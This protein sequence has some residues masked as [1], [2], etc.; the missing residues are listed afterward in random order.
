MKQD[1]ALRYSVIEWQDK[2]ILL[3]NIFV[4]KS[5]IVP[6]AEALILKHSIGQLKTRSWFD[7]LTTNG[8]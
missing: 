5:R 1:S 7:R 8:F 4:N 3:R 6:K 2:K